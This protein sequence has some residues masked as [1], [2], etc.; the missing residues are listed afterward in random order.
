MTHCPQGIPITEKLGEVQALVDEINANRP[1]SW[2][3]L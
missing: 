3:E 2:F 1:D